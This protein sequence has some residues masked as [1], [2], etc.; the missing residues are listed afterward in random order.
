MI[1]GLRLAAPA[2]LVAGC[3]LAT[4]S[5]AQA[6]GTGWSDEWDGAG[7]V[8]V[9]ADRTHI[10]VCDLHGDNVGFRVEYATNNPFTKAIE[11]L[12]A[13]WG[14]CASD[15]L[16]VSQVRV[17]KLCRGTDCKPSVWISRSPWL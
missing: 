4:A 5:P 2:L 12:K 14:K 3:L 10:E 1:T 11:S 17:F 8:T 9:S 13:P 15:R 7:R 6:A 16:W